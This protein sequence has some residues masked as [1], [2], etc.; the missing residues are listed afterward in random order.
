[1]VG[2]L[3]TVL[4]MIKS[5][6]QISSGDVQG[7][8]QMELAEGVSEA[9]ITTAAGLMIGI[10]A[11]VFYSIFRGRVQKYIAELEAA[12]THLMAL[13]HSQVERQ[14]LSGS[15]GSSHR[16]REDYGVPAPSPLGG[17]RQDLHGI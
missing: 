10:P 17:E 5:F 4:G 3:G 13:L 2:L 16:A 6:L 9:L 8:R 11:L 15:P 1:M 14:P 12:A 7:V